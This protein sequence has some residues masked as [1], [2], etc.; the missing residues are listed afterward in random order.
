MTTTEA[1][2]R[3]LCGKIGVVV[4][5]YGETTSSYGSTTFAARFRYTPA[6]GYSR[7]KEVDKVPLSTDLEKFVNVVLK[8]IE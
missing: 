1:T 5:F 7:T 2:L 4:E 8:S 6:H 3:N